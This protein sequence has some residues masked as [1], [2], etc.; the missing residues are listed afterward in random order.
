MKIYT[1]CAI[2]FIA[3][4][5]ASASTRSSVNYTI[6][7]DALDSAGGN[8]GSANYEQTSS[9]GLISGVSSGTQGALL[10]AGYV[11]QLDF[12]GPAIPLEVLSVV[13]RK[14]HGNAGTFDIDLPL[15]QSVGM[16]CRSS[17]PGGNHLVVVTFGSPITVNGIS[18]VSRDGQAGGV[19]AVND[20]VATISLTAVANAQTLQVTLLEASNGSTTADVVI[21]M[22]VLAGDTN[23]SS[24]V[25]ASDIGQ[26][27]SQSGQAAS[28]ANF[29]TDVN[30]SGSI[31]A[32]DIGLVKSNSGSSLP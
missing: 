8:T 7:A 27:K 19:V 21:P 11:A 30:A 12:G 13:S 16:E 9:A 18:V 25:T 24:S 23:G 17:G 29:R 6:L 26:T 32:S 4:N 22:G 2:F 28:G 31:T 20:T 10:R 5:L 14:V 3:A 1:L 15:T